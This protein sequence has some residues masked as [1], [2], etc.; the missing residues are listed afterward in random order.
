[1]A[2][3]RISA[4]VSN[5][6]FS[7][8]SATYTP[9][10]SPTIIL[11]AGWDDDVVTAAIPFTFRFNNIPYTSLRV[12]SNG[13]VTFGTTA[14]ST[15]NFAP[16]S[17][18]EG[19]AG[20]LAAFARDLIS[21]GSTIVT[22]FEGSA[23][24]RVFVIQWS[25]ARR[26]EFGEITSD[27]I[28]FQIRLY[29]TTFRAEVRFGSCTTS[30]ATALPVQ[31]GIRGASIADFKNR[32]TSSDWSATTAGGSNTATLST[33]S[34]VM[35]ASGLTFS[36]IAP[37]PCSGAPT[38]GAVTPASSIACPGIAPGPL[39]VTGQTTGV[40][41]LAYLWQESDDNGVSDPWATATTGTGFNTMTFQPPVLTTTKYY[42]VRVSCGI[43]QSFATVGVVTLGSCT[44]P[45]NDNPCGAVSLTVASTCTPYSDTTSNSTT[46]VTN[47]TNTTSNGVVAPDCS[48]AGVSVQDVW[49]KFTATAAT[50]GVTVTPVSGF[51]AGVQ[52]Y[53]VNSGT[54]GGSDL[55]LGLIGCINAGTEGT[56]EQTSL[57][58][59]IGQ[60]YYVRVYRHPSGSSGAA[61]SNSQF[62]VCVTTPVPVCTTNTAPAHLAT[63]VSLTPTLSW[64]EADFATNYDVYL[65]TT[66]GT[67]N[68]I[69]NTT[70]TQFEV[71]VPLDGS[72]QYFWYVVPKNSGASADCGAANETSFTTLNNCTAPT[73]LNASDITQTTATVSW[74][75]AS[76]APANGYEYEVRTG[77]AA[78]SGSSG[79]ITASTTA[80]GD[81]DDDL[82]G[83]AAGTVYTLYVRSACAGAM[84]SDW[85]SGYEFTT[86]ALL[87]PTID[88]FTPSAVCSNADA[89][90]RTVIVTGSHFTDA[91]NVSVNGMSIAAYTIDSDTQIT[92]IVPAAATS[93]FIEIANA[94]GTGTSATELT[95]NNAP[96][97]ADITAPGMVDVVCLGASLT[98]SSL[99]PNGQWSSSDENTATIDA[100]GVVTALELGAVTFTYTVTDAITG[101]AAF[102]TYDVTISE[103]VTV[104]EHPQSHTIAVNA[105]TTFSVEATGALTYAWEMSVD[106]APFEA[107]SDTAEF[108]GTQTATLTLTDVPLTFDGRRFRCVVTGICNA[109]NSEVATLTVG[110]TTIEVHPDDDA[111][112][113]PDTT[114]TD[115]TATASA[116][117]TAFQWQEDQGGGNWQ[118]LTNGGNYAGVDTTTLL[119]SGLSVANNGWRYRLQA[120]GL[121]SA[122]SD[123]ATLFVAQAASVQQQPLSQTA[124]ASGGSAEFSVDATGAESYVWHYSSDGTNWNPVSDNTPSGA[125]YSGASTET[126]IVNTNGVVAGTHLYSVVINGVAPCSSTQSD[127]VSL[128][129]NA[130][131]TV[132]WFVDADGD[133]FGNSALPSVFSCSQPDGY[134]SQAGDCNDQAATAYP[135]ASELPFNGIDDDCN[136]TTDENGSLTTSILPAHCGATLSS[137]NSLVGITTIPG[138]VVTRY[139]IRATLGAQTQTIETAVPHFS[140]AAFSSFYTY[141]TTYSI[142]VQVQRLGVWQTTWGPA[143]DVTTP[144]IL[145]EGGA[146]SVVPAQCGATL[147]RINTLIATTSL[148][149][150]TGY[151]FRITN[152]TDPFGPNAV[153]SIDRV[154]HWFGLNMLARFNYGTT[155]RVEVAV[156]T[157]GDFGQYGAACEVSSPAVPTIDAY[158]GAVVPSGATNVATISS[159]GAQQYRFQILRVADNATTI[160]DRP[161]HYFTFD[162]IPS[163][164]F[165]P[166]ALYYI[167]VAVMTANTWSP[168]GDACEVTA[169]G[170]AAKGVADVPQEPVAALRA[171]ISPNP[172]TSNFGIDLD[173][174]SDENVEV[175]VYDMLGKLVET[176]RVTV[177]DLPQLKLGAQYPAGV[178]N[179]IIDQAGV[180]KTMRIIKR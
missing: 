77:G 134:A 179:L 151:R 25:N 47:A 142:E 122:T 125:T 103:P 24:N 42:R 157:T 166:G 48:G 150:V 8:S 178:Y 49:F 168:F 61:Q 91:T 32:T 167:R 107:L 72:T 57:T 139:R 20:S 10:A 19:Y 1:M 58:T 118:N 65:G 90:G 92:L 180:V 31:S 38:P 161:I 121:T 100:S 14:P 79:L 81:T 131:A 112:C 74:T 22:G 98:L 124:C 117:A 84:F 40:S 144:N 154:V 34:T 29:E 41:G 75:A 78:G 156:K 45:A 54:C 82:V 88:G 172:F 3:N 83:L 101:C 44:P 73:N 69:G 62:S 119:L 89:A 164:I 146:G 138:A 123:P 174:A 169:P 96:T 37:T 70:E 111:I 120:T 102:K 153:Q 7:Q 160:I 128:T 66:S 116:D 158:C 86:E 35:P 11:A 145:Q 148:P 175:K 60:E 159:P 105:G 52:F 93:G 104:T 110:E 106:E 163:V 127:A 140:M 27:V 155:Y 152:L 115:F 136:G 67:T 149:G 33:S 130:N 132:E 113:S 173:V 147:A 23:P 80:A 64:A 114:T 126:L 162:Q 99:T 141:A 63:D 177:S 43:N 85:T 50:H 68:L 15:T 94:D 135:G 143:C 39:T 171:T 28:N 71:T 13:Y 59:S 26:Y 133:G 108:S 170:N 53:A 51:D 76:P 56:A 18:T 36:W 2:T 176:T 97:V 12:N 30:D 4:Q 87:P 17:T 5:Y 21:N 95:V 16:L 129:I 6:S 137:Y 9:L 46:N 55:S 109:E 165:T